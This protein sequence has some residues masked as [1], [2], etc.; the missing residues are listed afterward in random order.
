MIEYK[1]ANP[2]AFG[3]HWRPMS[4][5]RQKAWNF[6]FDRYIYRIFNVVYEKD[7]EEFKSAVEQAEFMRKLTK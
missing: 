4:Q 5:F 1:Y 7:S 2:K 3:N 6:A